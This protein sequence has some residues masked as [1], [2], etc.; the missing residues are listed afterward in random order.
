MA[1][2]GDVVL[3]TIVAQGCRPIGQPFQV[4]EAERNILLSLSDPADDVVR[5]PLEALQNLFP[6]LNE[7]DRMLA[8]NSLFIG[9]AQ[10]SFK[11]SLEAW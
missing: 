3:D 7:E 4:V 9:V 10:D 6:K 1:L 2:W 5:T 8:Q 11:T